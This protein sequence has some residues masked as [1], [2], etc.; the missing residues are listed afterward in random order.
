MKRILIP[1]DG[2]KVAEAAL[3]TARS[4][5]RAFGAEVFLLRIIAAAA[6]LHP[7]AD[8][9][10]D[11]GHDDTRARSRAYL[12][13]IAATFAHEGI[14]V[15]TLVVGGDAASIILEVAGD[16]DADLVVMSTH[17]RSGLERAVIGSVTDHVI[18]FSAAPV[19]VARPAETPRSAS[20]HLERPH[21]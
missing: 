9:Q 1:L 21:G 13:T 18:R 16:V 14:R 20:R 15:E 2:S 5:A 7:T 4:L 10:L 12:D 11:F 6:D 8:G 17:G 19:L 3:P